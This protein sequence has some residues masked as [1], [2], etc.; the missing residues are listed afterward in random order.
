[1]IKLYLASAYSDPDILIR[2]V[3]YQKAVAAS[4]ELHTLGYIVYAPIV[5]WHQVAKLYPKIDKVKAWIPYEIAFL[6][7]CDILC[8]LK[9]PNYSKSKGIRREIKLA[10]KL[11]KPVM[12]F[13][14]E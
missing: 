10:K 5:S 13:P 6:N 9:T 7:W 3:N 11:G 2:E 1:M 12:Y 14:W 8:V 4:A